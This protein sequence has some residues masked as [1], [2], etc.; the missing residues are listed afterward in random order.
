MDDA[1]SV[2]ASDGFD[3][4][5]QVVGAIGDR[6][7]TVLVE[8]LREIGA[9]EVLQHHVRKPALQRADIEH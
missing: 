3:G 7:G 8:D 9:V 5:E 1:E 4:L 6:H 2:S